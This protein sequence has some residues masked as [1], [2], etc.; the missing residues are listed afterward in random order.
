MNKLDEVAYSYELA[1]MK[2]EQDSRIRTYAESPP[3]YCASE[4]ENLQKLSEDA[5]RIYFTRPSRRCSVFN[6]IL[7]LIIRLILHFFT[8]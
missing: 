2:A 1:E 6:L 5:Q 8:F 3:L 7:A 4:T